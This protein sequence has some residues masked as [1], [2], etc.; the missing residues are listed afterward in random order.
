MLSDCHVDGTVLPWSTRP[1]GLDAARPGGTGKYPS[2]VV[3]GP[4]YRAASLTSTVK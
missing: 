2:A 4:M 3:C 1:E